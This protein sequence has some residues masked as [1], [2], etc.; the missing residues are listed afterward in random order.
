MII[1][2]LLCHNISLN[3]PTNTVT[4]HITTLKCAILLHSTPSRHQIPP[5]ITT[6][7]HHHSS[8]STPLHYHNLPHSYTT[9]VHHYS[10]LYCTT[11]E[12]ELL[13]SLWPPPHSLVSLF[14][15]HHILY[16][17]TTTFDNPPPPHTIFHRHH[18]TSHI[19][20]CLL[21]EGAGSRGSREHANVPPS[22]VLPAPSA[23]G[24]QLTYMRHALAVSV[25]VL[26][27]VSANRTRPWSQV[28]CSQT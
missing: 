26:A 22:P 25:R 20:N 6:I 28:R 13:T 21:T 23:N 8:H 11:I 3:N 24:S 9:I 2:A 10:I 18:H 4:R 14:H 7:T 1:V 16:S 27:W 15:H 17:T 19:T 12:I 5:H